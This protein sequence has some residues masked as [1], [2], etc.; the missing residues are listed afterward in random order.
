MKIISKY[1]TLNAYIL[2]TLSI[3]INM[4]SQPQKFTDSEFYFPSKQLNPETIGLW[5]EL[6]RDSMVH[7]DIY[8][9]P[10]LHQLSPILN[11]LHKE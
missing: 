7:R 4:Y 8:G 6:N 5:Q 3:Q 2:L 9:I 1:I 10:T 11:Y